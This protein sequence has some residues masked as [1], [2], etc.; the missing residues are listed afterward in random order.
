[1]LLAVEFFPSQILRHQGL[2]RGPKLNTEFTL[3]LSLIACSHC[4]SVCTILEKL[5]AAFQLLNII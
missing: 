1:M 2:F 3:M 4:E 5:V